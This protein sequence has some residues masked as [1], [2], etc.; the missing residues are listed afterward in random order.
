MVELLNRR[1]ESIATSNLKGISPSAFAHGEVDLWTFR[2]DAM[3]AVQAELSRCLSED[4]LAR[5]QR[6]HFDLHRNR[7]ITGRARLREILSRYVGSTPGELLFQTG[8]AGKPALA[9]W[10]AKSGIEFN[11]AHC[12]HLAVVAV[13]LQGR[14]GVDVER[15]RVLEGSMELVRQFFCP[16]EARL[17]AGLPAPDQA[18]AFFSLWTRKEAFLKATGQGIGQHLNR[19]EVSFLNGDEPKI[20]HL[21]ADVAAGVPASWTLC[22]LEPARGFVAA[23]AFEG[24]LPKLQARCWDVGMEDLLKHRP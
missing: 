17:F 20:L 9:S 18:A 15:V 4:E 23:V 6:Y 7:F 19:V 13:A 21:P 5:A 12:E 8:P 24:R 14:I 11:L 16:H 3:P 22:S 1:A 2:L 10:W